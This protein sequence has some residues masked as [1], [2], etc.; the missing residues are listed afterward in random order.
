MC[1]NQCLK[2]NDTNSYWQIAIKYNIE[3]KMIIN[4]LFG[5]AIQGELIGEKI[6]NN[7]YNIKS[8]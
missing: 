5:Y 4:N 3:N 8:I 6:Q 1:R 2:Y 7:P